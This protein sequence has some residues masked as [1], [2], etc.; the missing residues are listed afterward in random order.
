MTNLGAILVAVGQKFADLFRPAAQRGFD[1]GTYKGRR[2]TMVA[3]CV[4]H[5]RSG[6][7]GAR[8]VG[9]VY[10]WD[11]NHPVAYRVAASLEHRN[12]AAKVVDVYD[13]SGYNA[14]MAWLGRHLA[15]MGADLAVELHFN[16]ATGKAEGYEQLY[17]HTSREGARLAWKL[18]AAH[19][20]W[21]PDARNRG[22]KPK[23][24][25]DRGALFLRLTPCPAVIVEPFF[26][27]NP[28]EWD[29][30]SMDPMRLAECYAEGI[31]DYLTT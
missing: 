13:G 30:Y 12:I 26:G 29:A 14:S 17:W 20:R 16:A 15:D 7:R 24:A 19:E 6:D 8:S 23:G 28:D 4:G 22:V 5:S 10:E 18:N 27:D 3:I 2:R 21:Y 31:T 25:L 1:A 9:G 11:F